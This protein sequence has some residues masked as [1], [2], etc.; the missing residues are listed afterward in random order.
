MIRLA[1]ILGGLMGAWRLAR[2]DRS[3]LACFDI[4]LQGFWKSFWALA[5]VA[6]AAMLLDGIGGAFDSPRGLVAAT[7]IQ[8]ISTVIDAVAFPLVLAGLTERMGCGRH[9]IRFVVAN[10]WASL[11][12]MAIF[13]PV[14]LLA[15][16]NP[17]F[18]PVVAGVMIVL[19]VYEAYIAHVALEVNAATAAGIVL[20]D[21]LLDTLVAVVSKGML[22]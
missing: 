5:L 13:F 1:E 20:L 14:A 8:L 2:R 19:L 17:A 7:A 21:I 9:Y 10:N 15:E 18:Q 4:S 16:F 6:P 3:G 22:G 12:R 11:L